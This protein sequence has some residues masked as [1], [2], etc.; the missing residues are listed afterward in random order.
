M[1]IWPCPFLKPI[2]FDALYISL[3]LVL[4]Q[5][6]DFVILLLPEINLNQLGI[7]I[8]CNLSL[9]QIGCIVPERPQLDSDQTATVQVRVHF[10]VMIYMCSNDTINF[11]LFITY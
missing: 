4:G 10:V 7:L 3:S 6:H 5:V 11:I 2:H 1:C 8:S 9:L